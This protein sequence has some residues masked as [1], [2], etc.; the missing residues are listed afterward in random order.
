MFYLP[1]KCAENSEW[2]FFKDFNQE[3]RQILDPE[4]WLSHPIL[5]VHEEYELDNEVSVETASNDNDPMGPNEHIIE[6]AI[7]KYRSVID[8]NGRHH[9]FFK[10]IRKIHY[11]GNIPLNELA[12]YMS[13]CDY[14]DHQ[15]HR[16][17]QIVRDLASGRYKPDAYHK[18]VA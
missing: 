17:G 12:P 11:W 8:G 3:E 15:K 6:K 16:Y 5:P 10:A 13:R 4:L 14:D 2:S 1:S 9:E 18:N 7:A